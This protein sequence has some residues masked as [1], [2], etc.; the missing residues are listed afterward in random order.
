MLV[1]PSRLFEGIVP[2]SAI[3]HDNDRVGSID[4]VIHWRCIA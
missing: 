4:P 3:T 1:N 2:G